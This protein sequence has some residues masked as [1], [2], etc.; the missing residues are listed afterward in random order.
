MTCMDASPRIDAFWSCLKTMEPPDLGQESRT[1]TRSVAWVKAEVAALGVDLGL[2]VETVERLRAAALLYHDH[3]NEA[4]DLVQDMTDREG[5]LIHALVH[6]REPDFWNAKYW[7]RRVG[8]HPIYRSLGE[9]LVG[10]KGHA[11][12][13]AVARS[14]NLTGTVD[15]L[16]LTDAC[17]SVMRKDAGDPV[18]GFLRE[19]QEAEFRGLIGYLAGN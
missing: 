7:F 18:V 19:V 13:Q 2:G 6:R 4:H 5:A 10:L 1:G 11:S 3:H 15:P 8:D 9:Q 14:M 17:E 16:A 12:A